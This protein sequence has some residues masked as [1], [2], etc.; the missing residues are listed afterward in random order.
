MKKFLCFVLALTLLLSACGRTPA[1][2]TE[3]A[4]TAAPTTVPESTPKPTPAP[5]PEPEPAPEPEPDDPL[6]R[7]L[8]YLRQRDRD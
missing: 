1:Q 6:E 5:T 8:S 4:G 2:P 7:A 3:P